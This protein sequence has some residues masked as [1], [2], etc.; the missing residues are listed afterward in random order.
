[1]GAFYGS[2]L[3]RTENSGEV[4]KAL[5]EVAKITD[6]KFLVGPPVKGW[7]SVFPDHSGQSDQTS[8]EA[9]KLLPCDIFHL[10]VHDDDI[11]SY[12]FYRGGRLI[13]RYSSCPDY[14][15][16]VPDEEKKLCRGRP[17]LFQD[18]LDKPESLGK[19]KALLA[20]SQKKYTFEQERMTKFV[21][22]LGL[23]NALGSYRYLE[24]GERDGIKSWKQFIH[25][26]DL[27]AEK[28]SENAAQVRIKD[29]KKRLQKESILLAE[30][31]PPKGSPVL[32]D[33]LGWGTDTVASIA[34]KQPVI[35][36]KGVESA[37]GAATHPSGKFAVV[38]S[39][40]GL[41]IVDLEKKKLIKKLRVNRRM[42]TIDPFEGAPR[43]RLLRHC[44]KTWLEMPALREKL[45]IDEKLRVEILKD[46]NAFEK[47]TVESQQKI[48]SMTEQVRAKSSVTMET[49]EQVFD[50][51]FNPNG[52]QLFIAS[53]GIRVFAWDKLLSANDDTP[54]PELSV[55]A[56]R[57]DVTDPNSRP[58]AY[59]VRFDPARN[60]LLS[61]CLAGVVQYLNVKNG[62]SGTLLKPPDE[63]LSIW[64]LEFNSDR[65]AL[66]CHYQLRP[67][68]ENL[69]KRFCCLQ[70]WNYP[71]LCK[72]AGLD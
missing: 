4:Q 56:P 59:C 16:D 31:M 65:K 30:I 44:F 42:E 18:L 57:D 1:M 49:V 23:P 11:F 72:A 6:H 2:I 52:E 24:E 66:W 7:I 25:I 20:A 61:S 41:G 9:A 13:D 21:E 37:R 27:S 28:A 50:V 64:K 58:L 63:D 55:D 15:G 35:S 32:P 69:N 62:Q 68:V 70:I 54:A 47:L 22:L 8:A 46:P 51:C 14:F 60:L 71:A 40:G 3:I 45:G 12:F 53:K 17:E 10:I 33:T 48:K 38:I 39:Q 5:D 43:E 67:G 19:L 34:T 29:K 26:P 36:V